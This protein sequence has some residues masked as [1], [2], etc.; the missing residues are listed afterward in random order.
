VCGISGIFKR[1]GSQDN[2][3]TIL[4]DVI[5]KL[6]SIY[7]EPFAD[8]SQISMHLVAMLTRRSV[9]VALS[10][11][12]RDELF[13]GYNRPV[14]PLPAPI[15][16]VLKTTMGMIAPEPSN[17]IGHLFGKPLPEPLVRQLLDRHIS[18]DLID[19]GKTGFFN[20]E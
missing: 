4:P 2:L 12:A 9:I 10:G 7:D 19:R 13:G 15:R 5:P 14:C 8:S 18:R 3:G 11:D 16:R 1:G 6:A 20:I 17:T